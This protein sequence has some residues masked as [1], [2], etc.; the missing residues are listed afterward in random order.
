M[1]RRGG[2]PKKQKVPGVKHVIAVTSGKGGVGKSTIAGMLSLGSRLIQDVDP[3][4][5]NQ[6]I[7]LWQ[8]PTFLSEHQTIPQSREIH[9]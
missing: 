1:P 7:S 8:Y 5:L 9:V 6:P 4:L 3:L 2:P